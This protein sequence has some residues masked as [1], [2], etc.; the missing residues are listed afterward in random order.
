[1]RATAGRLGVGP[2]VTFTG[3]VEDVR[4]WQILESADAYVSST[5]HEGF[6]LVYLE[7]MAAGLPVI[8]S[9]HGGQVDFLQDGENGY[10]VRPSDD[11]AIAQAIG[12]LLAEPE[13]RRRIRE[14]NLRDA[15]EHRSERCARAYE[16]LF[17][18]LAGAW[19]RRSALASAETK[20]SG[21]PV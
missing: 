17:D 12:R 6:G 13:A 21:A 7:A 18:R 8:T 10:L 9:D 11:A 5:M 16:Q 19:V 15:Q 2:R 3:W 4:K 20:A 1:M 14:T